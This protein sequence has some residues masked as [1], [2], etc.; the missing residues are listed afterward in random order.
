MAV[1]ARERH[2][3]AYRSSIYVQG[4]TAARRLA[5]EER[6]RVVPRQQEPVRRAGKNVRRNRD[7]ALYM[8]I[9]YVLFLVA[10]VVATA[11]ILTGYLTLKADITSSIK[12]ISRMESTLNELK[13]SNDEKYDR[14]ISNVNLDEVKRIAIQELGMSYAKEG[15]IISFRGEGSDYVRQTGEIP[16]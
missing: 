9:G 1:N 12:N 15:Q 14:I 8:N 10:A 11:F 4:N 3:N 7:R 13:L 6:I 2:K 5:Q 16:E